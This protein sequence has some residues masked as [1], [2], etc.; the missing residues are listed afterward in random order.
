MFRTLIGLVLMT[1]VAACSADSPTTTTSSEAER[2]PSA[3]KAVKGADDF[4][5][6]LQ[7]QN[8]DVDPMDFYRDLA[9]GK[10]NTAAYGIVSSQQR[11]LQV[12][13]DNALCFAVGRVA[14]ARMSLNIV[15]PAM[16]EATRLLTEKSKRS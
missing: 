14:E 6:G 1:S 16:V 4:L 9:R 15:N 5:A 7:E 11:S 13:S 2:C 12:V 8:P 10:V 3:K